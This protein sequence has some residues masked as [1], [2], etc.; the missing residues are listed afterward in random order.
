MPDITM[1]KGGECPLKD[2]CYRYRAAPSLRQ[3]YFVNVPFGR[4][5]E[6]PAK[7]PYYWGLSKEEAVKP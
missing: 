6:Q 7:C 4:D 3:S 1:C 2:H 5:R